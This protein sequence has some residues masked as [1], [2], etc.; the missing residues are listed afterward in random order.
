MADTTK[1]IKATATPRQASAEKSKDAEGSKPTKAT[2]RKGIELV[3]KIEKPKKAK[4]AAAMPRKTTL[5]KEKVVA[6]SQ[7]EIVSREMIEQV[8]YEL[9]LQRGRQH[10]GA[11]EDW[12][13]AEQEL[14][15]RAS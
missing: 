8:A 9:W 2:A 13:R 15:G 7:P 3:A 10:G 1:R 6:I 11:L 14:R 5:K 12:I 4:A